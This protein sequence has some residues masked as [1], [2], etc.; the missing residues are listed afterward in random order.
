MRCGAASPE[1]AAARA[2]TSGPVTSARRQGATPSIST[3]SEKLSTVRMSTISASTS[4]SVSD[5]VEVT[6]LT[7][8]AATSTSSPSRITPPKLSRS[9]RNAVA[10]LRDRTQVRTAMP[11]ATTNPMA[12]ADT[13][14]T[15]NASEMVSKNA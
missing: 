6:V 9:V 1:R 11:I 12:I 14:T 4:A 10:P 8:S 5:G 7:R 3:C 2:S 13:P 15:S